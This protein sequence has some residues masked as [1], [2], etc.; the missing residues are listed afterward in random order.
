MNLTETIRAE[1]EYALAQEIP[2]VFHIDESANR[3][4][5]LSAS[6]GEVVVECVS[7]AYLN[8]DDKLTASELAL[9]SELGWP[10]AKPQENFARSWAAPAN[11]EQIASFL[12][13]TVQ[14]VFRS[15][16]V[17]VERIE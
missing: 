3:Y 9:L 16:C 14:N 1:I 7:N 15:S 8:G 10:A 4:V 6:E 5:Q 2:V 13:A 11:A 17:R 12:A